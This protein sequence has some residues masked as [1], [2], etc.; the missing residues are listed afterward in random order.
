MKTILH[1]GLHKTATTFLQDCF[2]PEVS[3]YTYLSRS[4]T[5]FNHAMNRLQ[6]ADESLYDESAVREQLAEV[7][8]DRL[9]ISDESLTGKP[10]YFS[11]INRSL[12]ANRLHRLFPDGEVILFLRDQRDIIV[13][14]YS[15][16]IKM[17]YGVKTLR[18]LFYRPGPSLTYQEYERDRSFHDMS[19]LYFDS[20]DY[21]IHL[22]CFRYA[23][24]VSLYQSLFSKVH[25]FLYEDFVRDS[26]AIVRRLGEIIEE[27]IQPRTSDRQNVSLT[28]RQIEV[29][30]RT[31]AL[32]GL[33]NRAIRKSLQAAA[34]VAPVMKTQD[35]RKDAE[36]IT[37]GY[38][39]DNN[40]RLKTLLPDLDWSLCSDKYA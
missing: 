3:S 6:Y 40:R 31:N 4:F 14:H 19:R 29:K 37:A 34:K 33:G 1:I 21:H 25:V 9:L 39:S 13:S 11:Y 24:L 17:P 26:D 27:D 36:E 8:G 28:A 32:S 5:Q 15:S 10:V 18:D 7:P 23:E 2:W 16:Y 20:N 35:L 12:I 38:Y 22:D 30:R